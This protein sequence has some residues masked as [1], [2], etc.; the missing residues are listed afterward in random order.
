MRTTPVTAAELA[1]LDGEARQAADDPDALTRVGIRFYQAGSHQ[2]AADVLTA[3]LGLRPAFSTAVYLGLSL[4]ALQRFD[5]AETAYR[6]A[7][8]LG[9]G[10]DQRE[11]LERRLAA[12]GKARLAA[13]ARQ[14]VAREAELSSQ[15]AVPNSIAVLPWSYVGAD[16]RLQP[17]GAGIPHLLMTDLGKIGSVTLVERERIQALLEEAALARSGRVD[18]ATAVRSGRLL[19]AA[20]VVAGVVRETRE[21]VQLQASAYRTDGA[22]LDASGGAS[23][24]VERLFDMEKALVLDLV[25]QLGLAVSPAERRAVSERPTADLQAFLAFSEGLTAQDRG[26]YRAAGG[27]FAL[28]SGRDPAFGAARRWGEANQVLLAASRSSPAALARAAD[29]SAPA[30]GSAGRSASLYSAMQV[31]APSTGGEVDLRSRSPITTP[32]LP[33]ALRQDNPS[34][35]AI[36]GSIIIIIPRP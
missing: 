29:P 9:R 31:I 8:V 15:P 22:A 13:E 3:A 1:R 35:I 34:R 21:G 36:I 12:L 24:K 30:N 6:T 28:A 19:R 27:Y 7:Q 32:Q 17:L 5:E 20:W 25:D 2:R 14:A 26:D 10:A 18:S 4:E 16:R 33:E 11:E 23:D